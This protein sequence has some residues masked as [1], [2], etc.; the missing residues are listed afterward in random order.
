MHNNDQIEVLRPMTNILLS[1]GAQPLTFTSTHI[2]NTA[3]IIGSR[4]T[5]IRSRNFIITEQF[6][7]VTKK[8]I[9]RCDST[10]QG[11]MEKHQGMNFTV[12]MYIAVGE[13]QFGIQSSGKD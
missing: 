1:A 3:S 13:V 6:V 10:S 4:V 2:D 5:C 9:L 8:S 12:V 7:A 11:H